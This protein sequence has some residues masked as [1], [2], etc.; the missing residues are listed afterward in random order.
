MSN[1]NLGILAVVAAVMVIGAVLQSR[2]ARP[3]RAAPSGPTFLIQGLDTGAIASI[4]VGHGDDAV[5]M[6]RRNGSFV[7]VNKANYPADARRIN[8]L[9][10]KCLDI[11]KSELYTSNA[12]NHEA[13]EVTEADAHGL[14]KFLR[15]DGSLLTGVV[16]GKSPESGQGAFVR[17]VGSDDVFV[18]DRAPWFRETPI[19]FVD[20]EL[21]AV[22]ADD[23]NSVT[24]STPEG[25]YTLRPRADGTGAVM[26]DLPADKTLKT[27]DARSVLTA[28]SSL[29]FDD[30]NT[31][32]SLGELD[33]DHGY[34]CLLD[35]SVR[36][37]LKL[38][39]KDGKT[40]VQC[41]A[42]YTD[43]APVTIQ[44]GGSEPEE[45]LRRKEAK[46]QAQEHALTFTQRHKG[47]VY[48]IP[49]WRADN[50]TKKPADLL[51]DKPEPVQEE[52]VEISTEAMETPLDFDFVVDPNHPAT[53]Q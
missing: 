17:L 25:A 4:I 26:E 5:E 34:V 19:E 1:R 8:E 3:S 51:E 9:L 14:V 48:T 40:Y 23:V 31:P 21:F 45:E 20:A 6:V 29:S 11:K 16:I 32:A 38:A 47:W 44:R 43:T 18:A 35:N 2:L 7:V 22:E 46:L 53:A 33:F 41:E 49:E 52:P 12:R 50:L 39:R 30:V 42:V 24:V 27:S 13:L 15:A 36:Y 28:L 37:T 10:S